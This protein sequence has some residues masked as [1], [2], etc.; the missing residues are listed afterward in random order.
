MH[1]GNAM[2]QRFLAVITKEGKWHV[3]YCPEL[4][5]SS[6]GRTKKSALNNLKEAVEIYLEEDPVGIPE[7]R[8]VT[9]FKV[10]VMTHA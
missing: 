9:E 3:S 6:Q 7:R 8:E 10:K 2:E 1:L 5:V 4:G